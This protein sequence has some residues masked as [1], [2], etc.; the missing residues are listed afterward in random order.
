ML[1]DVPS[2][3]ELWGGAALFVDPDDTVDLV[4]A[5]RCA[6][7]HPIMRAALGARARALDYSL[8]R[9]A[10]GYLALYDELCGRPR[11]ETPRKLSTTPLV[12]AP[13]GWR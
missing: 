9:M 8:D 10:L 4:R 7:E 1:G 2:L 3:R 13:G 5:L 11:P 12:D 6:I